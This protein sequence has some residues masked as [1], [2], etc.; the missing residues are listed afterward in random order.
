MEEHRISALHYGARAVL[1][2]GFSYYIAYLVRNDRLYYY[3]APQMTGYVKWAA[4]A[5]FVV[6][7][8]QGWLAL[9][10]WSGKAQPDCGCEH[11][12]SRSPI[13]HLAIYS[14]FLTPLALGFALP[15]RLMGSELAAMKGMSLSASGAVR[16][17]VSAGA[18]SLSGGDASASS[19][20]GVSS[21]A[22]AG[23]PS[24]QD[25][26]AAAPAAGS[27]G[28]PGEAAAPAAGA[29]AVSA[30]GPP[31]AAQQ[32]EEEPLK[33]LFKGDAFSEPFAAL[34]LRLYRKD[35]IAIPDKGFMEYLTALDLYLHA[36]IGKQVELS[37]FVYRQ[38][39]LPQK[40][41]VVSRL[42][43]QCC[44]ADAS[45]YGVLAEARDAE[46]YATD[47]WVKL[48]G[49]VSKTMLGG[50]EIMKLDAVSVVKIEAPASPYIYPYYDEFDELG[51]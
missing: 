41:F 35:V 42:A 6:A 19:D 36:F 8:F 2:A 26:A 34:G 27:E 14:L 44:S 30:G 51:Q 45:P 5:I 11:T 48:R 18:E 28:A 13:A 9:K 38:D 10:A 20:S 39:D 43:M 21:S 17:A 12:P 3:I 37:G 31:A 22:T 25:R 4:I 24:A 29:S 33:Q 16:P 15:D 47:S 7:V 1:M 32:P 46:Q 23:P 40:Q 50:M 49:T